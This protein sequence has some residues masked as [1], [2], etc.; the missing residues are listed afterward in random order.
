MNDCKLF[1]ST[2]LFKYN[3]LQI[4]I[5]TFFCPPVKFLKWRLSCFEFPCATNIIRTVPRRMEWFR[6]DLPNFQIPIP[7]SGRRNK[8]TSPEMINKIHDIVLNDP[9]VKVREIA[10]IV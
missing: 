10:E 7:S 5:Q 9:K 1:T 3:V 6:S 2:C 8:I 4:E